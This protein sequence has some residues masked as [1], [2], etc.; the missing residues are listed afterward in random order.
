MW[1]FLFGGWDLVDVMYLSRKRYNFSVRYHVI[2]IC[3]RVDSELDKVIGSVGLYYSNSLNFNN[4]VKHFVHSVLCYKYK[5]FRSVILKEFVPLFVEPLSSHR[6]RKR[7]A[8]CFLYYEFI[9]HTHKISC[10]SHHLDSSYRTND[11]FWN[12]L[13]NSS[14]YLYFFNKFFWEIFV[15]KIFYT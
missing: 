4:I 10:Q 9:S 8:I 6:L 15:L 11:I 12:F 14:T 5:R 1:N 13:I 2:S 7:L 3:T